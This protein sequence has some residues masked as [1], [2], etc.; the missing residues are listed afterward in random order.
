MKY[1][2][3]FLL[4]IFLAFAGKAQENNQDTASLQTFYFMGEEHSLCNTLLLA[5]T[6]DYLIATTGSAPLS[7][8]QFLYVKAWALENCKN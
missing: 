5:Q 3:T 1:F 4:F 6:I 7:V 2:T 8:R